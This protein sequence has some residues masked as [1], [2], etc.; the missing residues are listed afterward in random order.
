MYVGSWDDHLYA[1]DAA[2][3]RLVWNFWAGDNVLTS[4][5]ASDGRVFFG[6]DDGYVYALNALASGVE[7]ITTGDPLDEGV[8]MGPMRSRLTGGVGRYGATKSDR[9]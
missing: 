7:A 1:L 4:A 5:A 6:S 8:A 2:T 3:G 9:K